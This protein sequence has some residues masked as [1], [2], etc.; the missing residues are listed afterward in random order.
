MLKL[1]EII[2][3][4]QLKNEGLSITAIAERTG[5]DRKT[6]RKYLDRGLEAPAYGPR[7]PRPT[8]LDDFKDYIAQRL[9]KYPRLRATRLLREIRELG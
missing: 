8:C 4:Q 9:Q 6:V 5:L 1:G 3:I 7:T 2:V